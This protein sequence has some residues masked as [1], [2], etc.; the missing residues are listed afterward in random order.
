MR[1][2]S[3]NNPLA[4]SSSTFRS[5]SCHP[6]TIVHFKST[7]PPLPLPPFLSIALGDNNKPHGA[8]NP[9]QVIKDLGKTLE[10]GPQGELKTSPK[11]SFLLMLIST[12]SVFSDIEFW[13][14]FNFTATSI[15]VTLI[16][17]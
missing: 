6:P 10:N 1:Y 15:L 14:I 5:L 3:R 4:G 16:H 2:R 11:L 8:R 9:G 13:D 12:D 17:V 7:A